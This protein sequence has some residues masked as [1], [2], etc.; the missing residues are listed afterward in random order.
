MKQ[1]N[2]CK[3]Q[4]ERQRLLT[5]SEQK[6]TSRKQ[7]A[8]RSHGLKERVARPDVG[9]RVVRARPD[10]L[11]HN[12]R[13]ATAHDHKQTRAVEGAPNLSLRGRAQVV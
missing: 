8:S 6:H 13:G 1:S 7:I 10:S 9:E 5:N 12:M 3:G 4:R 11:R 2:Q